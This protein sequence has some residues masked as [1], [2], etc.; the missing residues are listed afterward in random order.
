LTGG[1]FSKG[2]KYILEFTHPNIWL[3]NAQNKTHHFLMAEKIENEV[4][5]GK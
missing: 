3:E 4:A 5:S 2:K 1:S